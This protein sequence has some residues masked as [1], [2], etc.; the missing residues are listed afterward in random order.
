M[1]ASIAFGAATLSAWA[2]AAPILMAIPHSQNQPGAATISSISAT[3]QREM[4]S[5]RT[6]SKVMIAEHS[7]IQEV[8]EGRPDN[9]PYTPSDDVTPSKALT[10]PRPL[11]TAYLLS[12]HHRPGSEKLLP[13]S[14]PKSDSSIVRE[15]T[16]SASR[17]SNPTTVELETEGNR[18]LYHQIPCPMNIK[19]VHR[20]RNYA[21]MAVVSVVLVFIAL[22]AIIELWA[23]I[24]QT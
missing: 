24:C 1:K 17:T 3:T 16:G 2:L 9:R 14:H 12:L 4:S 18:P 19:H 21:D 23:P 11:K 8:L 5:S 7:G 22:V 15:E 10:S 20:V 6:P 13:P